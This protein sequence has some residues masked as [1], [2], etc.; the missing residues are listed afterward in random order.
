MSNLRISSSS[1]VMLE[2]G[3]LL[4][5]GFVLLSADRDTEERS[6]ASL[7]ALQES[8]YDEKSLSV[9][10]KLPPLKRASKASSGD[11]VLSFSGVRETKTAGII[12]TVNF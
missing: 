4:K 3:K 11:H 5:E 9:P 12:K 10:S 7:V 2:G 1:N 8:G 6:E